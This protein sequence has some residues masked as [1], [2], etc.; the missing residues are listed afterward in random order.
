MKT[1]SINPLDLVDD[2][3]GIHTASEITRLKPSTLYALT[4]RRQIPHYKK[5]GRLHFR[6]SELVAWMLEYR[7]EIIDEHT[8]R[9]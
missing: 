9:S 4:S 1:T 8:R 7:R 5:R 2:I 3:I 6:R